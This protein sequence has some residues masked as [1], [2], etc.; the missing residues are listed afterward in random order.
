MRPVIW[1]G[2]GSL[3]TAPLQVA[4]SQAAL[5]IGEGA[6]WVGACTLRI[7]MLPSLD[8]VDVGLEC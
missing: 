7:V 8:N 4:P 2:Q 5:D 3:E 6:G 1:Q